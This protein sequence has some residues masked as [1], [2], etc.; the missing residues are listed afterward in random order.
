MERKYLRGMNLWQKVLSHIYDLDKI[1]AV[2]GVFL[3]LLMIVLGGVGSG[4]IVF[5]LVGVLILLS[6]LIWLV[7]RKKELLTFH[8]PTS[9]T[10]VKFWA[11][12]FFVLYI[13]SVVAV[14]LRPGLYERPILYFF[15]TAFMAG[16][17]ALGSLNA[18]RQHAGFILVQIILLGISIGWSQMLIFPG[19]N[20]V[21]AW[22]HS[23]IIQRIVYENHIP[24]GFAYS[25]LPI[26]HLLVGITSLITVLP[27]KLSIMFTSS[28][29]QI[30]G[31]ATF[32]FLIATSLFK[33]HRIGLLS[34]LLV[35]LGDW[36]IRFSYLLYP[37]AFGMVFLVIIL[38]LMF[39]RVKD[40]PRLAISIPLILIMAC[41]ILT[42]SILAVFMAILLFLLWG[43]STVYSK[44]Y[45]QVNCYIRLLIPVG[46]IVAMFAWWT[47]A[48]MHTAWLG[49]LISIGFDRETIEA[50]T[51]NLGD[52]SID[53]GLVDILFSVLP[54]YLFA[55]ISFIGVLYM[56]SQKGTNSTFTYAMLSITPLLI[57]FVFY[58][59]GG[60]AVTE[61]WFY[62]SGV[63]LS[64]P[65][66]LVIYWLG[67]SER[68]PIYRCLIFLIFI[69]VFSFLMITSA[70]GNHDNFSFP[71]SD[72]LKIYHT[73]SELAG[74][75][76]FVSKSTQP[77]CIDG[78]SFPVFNHYYNWSNY[79]RIDLSYTSGEF[80]HDGTAKLLRHDTILNFQRMGVLSSNIHTDIYHYMSDL[81]F[82][83]IYDNSGLIGYV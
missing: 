40:V 38:Y 29:G 69:V 11:V 30:A 48:S 25:M 46:F 66:S 20:G 65:L 45:Q 36:H 50:A 39:N 57:S 56:V 5:L 14:Y 33:N 23:N 60:S 78:F 47:Y 21:D 31:N 71:P 79:Q 43:T 63:L 41:I 2:I 82:S 42:H 9:G 24:D 70:M 77:L 52:A 27:I 53:I 76:F 3:S 1:F 49:Y 61:R 17:I 4:N 62:F 81:G 68:K 28:L 80:N 7:I 51:L 72:K 44:L 22:Y 19:V 10:G 55:I 8:F 13:T 15:L 16:A 59:S 37:N 26:L 54:F 67:T 75:D 64:I 83:K 74:Y 18:G 58:I 6:C 34:A 12:C 73:H 32:I 35:I